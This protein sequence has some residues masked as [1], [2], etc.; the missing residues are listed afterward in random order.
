MRRLLIAALLGALVVPA[1][2]HADAVTDWNANAVSALVTS[3]G[4]SPTVSTVH[5]AMVHGAVYDAVN[6][7]DGRHDAYLVDVRARRW[8]SRDAAAATAAYRVLLGIVPAQQATLA[9]QY[10]RSLAAIPAGPAKSGG[11][12]V[13]EITAAAMLT[14]RMGDGRFGTYRF[15]APANPADPWPA[16]QWRPVLPAFV[17]DPAAWMKDVR[18]FIIADPARYASRGPDPLTSRRYAR[19]FDEV[20]AVGSATSTTRTPDQTDQARFWAEGPQPWTRVARQ[21]VVDRG[22]SSADSARMFAQLYMAGADTIISVW[23]DK[24]RWLCWR[25][26]TAIREAASD[27]NPD[28]APDAGWTPLIN[29]PPYP[30]QPSGLS[31]VSA[32]MAET[33][34]ATFGRHVRFSVTSLSSN[35]TRT[36]DSFDDA[37]DE[38]VDARVAAGIHFRKA[39]E[40][41]ATIGRRVS[42]HVLASG[43]E[44][45]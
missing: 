29:T 17:N 1:S 33:L 18:P 39:D 31:S 43:F 23:T 28:T 24:A 26:I 2:A 4:Q 44:R 10:D 15:P 11:I 13:G 14:A 38:V 19:E 22:L 6:S 40:D 36:F 35:T 12:A 20:K 30:D 9:A 27:G 8:Y 37:V 16:G 45:D 5:L 3:A 32:A 34:D 25:P 7:I 21:L 42:R 41:G